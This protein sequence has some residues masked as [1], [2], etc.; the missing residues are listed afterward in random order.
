MINGEQET[1]LTLFY[2]DEGV[3]SG[4]ITG[5]RRV[6]IRLNDTIATLYDRVEKEGLSLLE[7]M[8]PLIAEGEAPPTPQKETERTVWPQRR[9]E[10]AEINWF[11]SSLSAY[12][13]I[14]A[15]TKP[16]PGAFT[17]RKGKI[18]Y[19]GGKSL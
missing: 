7:E 18:D 3:D 2:F 11:S 5:Q 16:Y 10:D 4:D 15:Q 17:F 1:G 12:D 8:F 19:M 14:R 9:P 6:A 13:L